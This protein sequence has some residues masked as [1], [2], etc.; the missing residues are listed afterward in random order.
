MSQT[1]DHVRLSD[2]TQ[3]EHML[4]WAFR[5]NAFGVGGCELVRRQFEEACGPLGLEALTALTVFVRELGLTGRRKVTL[6]APGS[7]RLTRD[8]QSVLAVFASAQDEDYPRLEA[9]LAWL[10]ADAPRAPFP[11][12]ACLV[13][14]AL[15][16]SGLVLRLPTVE[17]APVDP[18]EP[19]DVVIPFPRSAARTA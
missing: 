14:Q 18:A 1:R 6:A 7:H 5:A 13:A 16:M 10:L 3:G 8:E 11:A 2:L 4:L 17:A 15:S 9:H 12:A 19:G